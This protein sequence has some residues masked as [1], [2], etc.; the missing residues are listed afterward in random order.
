MEDAESVKKAMKGAYAVFLVTNYWETA[1]ADTERRQGINV[2][3]IAKVC[4]EPFSHLMTL[5]LTCLYRNLACS[6]SFT[7]VC[8][9]LPRV[10]DF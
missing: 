5:W 10:S 4:A 1:S 2:A 7:A 3:N 8:L 9:I 6:I